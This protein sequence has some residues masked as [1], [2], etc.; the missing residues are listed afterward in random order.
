MWLPNAGP[1]ENGG[2]IM[3]TGGDGGGGGGALLAT[4]DVAA[5]DS[6]V[7]IFM[8]GCG[9]GSV[10]CATIQYVQPEIP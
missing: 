5:K 8:G 7:S 2:M 10:G 9:A 4:A 6:I 3:R 1:N